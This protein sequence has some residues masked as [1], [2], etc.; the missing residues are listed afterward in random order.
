MTEFKY[1]K[2]KRLMLIN[3]QCLIAGLSTSGSHG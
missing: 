1:N 3:E 2:E